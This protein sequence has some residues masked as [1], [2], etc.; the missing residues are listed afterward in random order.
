MT[1][2][3]RVCGTHTHL[4]IQ[5]RISIYMPWPYISYIYIYMQHSQSGFSRNWKLEG[6]Q[7]WM[8]IW[9]EYIFHGLVEGNLLAENHCLYHVGSWKRV[10]SSNSGNGG[11]GMEWEYNTWIYLDSCIH[12]GLIQPR[13][14]L[15]TLNKQTN[16]QIKS[17]KKINKYDSW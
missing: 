5:V 7:S 4:Y 16:K 8:E 17:N 15:V 14:C 13:I 12:D 10:P 3:T 2:I 9:W 11:I 6:A 1:N